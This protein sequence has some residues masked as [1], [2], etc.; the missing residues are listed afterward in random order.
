MHKFTPECKRKDQRQ[1]LRKERERC[2]RKRTSQCWKTLLSLFLHWLRRYQAEFFQP[3]S[4]W[5]TR[6]ARQPASQPDR[7]PVSQFTI[8]L[9]SL[10]W[11]EPTPVCTGVAPVASCLAS[12]SPK[13]TH[14]FFHQP[15]SPSELLRHT[16][17]HRTGENSVISAYSSVLSLREQPKTKDRY[18][19]RCPAHTHPAS[20][21]CASKVIDAR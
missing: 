5:A 10:S 13:H 1:I 4:Q 11:S 18:P 9:V 15:L 12:L 19:T 2:G 16:H 20:L 14:I 6:P 17:T 7:L 8:W 21:H 3:D